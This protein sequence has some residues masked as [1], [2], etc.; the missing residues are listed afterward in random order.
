MIS[1]RTILAVALLSFGSA[2]L[3]AQDAN[4]TPAEAAQA[5]AP[6]APPAAVADMT[7][8]LSSASDIERTV[9]IYQCDNGEGFRVQYI[10]AAPNFLALVPVEGEVHVFVTTVSASGAR[11]VS[12]PYEW[13]TKGDDA[14]L[15]DLQ[16]EEG[17]PPLATCLAA[18]NT[19]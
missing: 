4:E 2:P 14:T 1:A 7:L 13:S 19:P 18:S 10:N 11:Y 8:T 9:A 16:A 5:A 15:S 6:V 17:A 12:G 3:L